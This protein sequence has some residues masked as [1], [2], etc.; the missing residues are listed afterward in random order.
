MQTPHL[1]VIIMAAGQGKRMNNPDLSKVMHT[2]NGTPLIEHV[3]YLA[4]RLAPERIVVIVGHCREQ[5]IAHLASV[6]P[7]V[8]IAVQAEQLGTGHAIMQARALL[9][10]FDGDVVILSG[11]AP[12]T[13]TDTLDAAISRHRAEASVVTVLTALL[14]DPTGYGRVIKDDEG[15]IRYIVE[16]KDASEEEKTV[17]EIN[18]GI[19]VFQARPLFTALS[20]ITND[21]AQGEYYLTDVF[22]LFRRDGL[23]MIAELVDDENEIRGINTIAQLQEMEAIHALMYGNQDVLE[24]SE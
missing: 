1:A 16:Q 10:D 14:D 15:R 20:R 8:R 21:N 7:E 6:A 19:Y 4:Q 22:E 24:T 18:S 12:L 17:R 11:D 9:E 23:P 5:V 3:T 2:L 13:R